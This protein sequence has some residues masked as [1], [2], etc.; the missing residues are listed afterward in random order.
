M[1]NVLK[2][3]SCRACRRGRSYSR[4]S[5]RTARVNRRIRRSA[6]VALRQGKEPERV[7]SVP[8]TD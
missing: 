3:C 2:F 7:I 4:N 5:A 6:K 1:S 8:Y